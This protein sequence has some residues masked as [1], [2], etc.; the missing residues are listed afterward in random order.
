MLIIYCSISVYFDGKRNMALLNL[1]KNG[2]ELQLLYNYYN[3]RLSWCGP[4]FFFVGRIIYSCSTS[5]HHHPVQ[6]P[7]ASRLRRF[8]GKASARSFQ[9]RYLLSSQ[10]HPSPPNTNQNT[11]DTG[12]MFSWAIKKKNMLWGSTAHTPCGFEELKT[13][14]RSGI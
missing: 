4:Q 11:A 14:L 13:P 5:L 9:I 1:E 10:R 3:Y 6:L 2:F 7:I 8:G 12:A